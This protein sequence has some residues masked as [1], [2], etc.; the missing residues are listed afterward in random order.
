METTKFEPLFVPEEKEMGWKFEINGQPVNNIRFLKASNPR[1]GELFFA[2]NG[3]FGQ[4]LIKQNPGRMVIYATKHSELGWLLGGAEEP[5]IQCNGS[6]FTAAG[7]YDPEASTEYEAIQKMAEGPDKVK[8][9]EEYGKKAAA[10]EILQEMG[11]EVTVLEPVGKGLSN[12][13]IYMTDLTDTSV[14]NGE[15]YYLVIFPFEMLASEDGKYFIRL[16]EEKEGDVQPAPEWSAIKKLD[17]RP[18]LDCFD[19]YDSVAVTGYAKTYS[20]LVRNAK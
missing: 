1:V 5:R 4:P 19:S 11:L 12:R 10:R 3:R 6:M 7:G 15:T 9:M 14:W 13:S 17:F 18:V 2:W 20:W 8:A 16:P